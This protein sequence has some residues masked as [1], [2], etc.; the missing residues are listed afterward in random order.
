MAT[1]VPTE[2]APPHA[3]PAPSSAPAHPW[4]SPCPAARH[5]KGE[6]NKA[7]NP[8][9]PERALLYRTVAEHFETWLDLA[10]PSSGNLTARATT[11]PRH[12]T[13]RRLFANNWNAASL[14]T[15]LHA[16]AVTTVGMT[17]WSL[18]PARAAVSA[19]RATPGAWRRLLR[20]F[21]IT[22]S[23]SYRCASECCRCPN[24]CATISSATRARSMRHC[25][26]SCAWCSRVCKRIAPALQR[27]PASLHLGAVALRP[28]LWL[29]PEHACALSC[30]RGLWD[31]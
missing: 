29:Q 28:P 1:P 23:P 25:A 3:R 20:T 31:V 7:Y 22:Y 8:R 27:H 18:S 4:A 30:V 26:S 13:W 19:P 2:L 6:T 12:P 21:A 9:H 5:V 15:A 16:P 11:T 14:P 24:A 17:T 10:W